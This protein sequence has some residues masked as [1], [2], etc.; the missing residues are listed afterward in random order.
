MILFFG[1]GVG[2]GVVDLQNYCVKN[3]TLFRG[4]KK[5]HVTI[6]TCLGMDCTLLGEH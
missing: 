4:S 6:F 1:V 3:K 5:P 2:V